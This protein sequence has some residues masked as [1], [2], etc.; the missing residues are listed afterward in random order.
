MSVSS[1]LSASLR[2]VKIDGAI[3]AELLESVKDQIVA[4]R[5]ASDEPLTLLID[6]PGG[7]PALARDLVTFLG[8]DGTRPQGGV[9]RTLATGTTGGSAAELLLSGDLVASMTP[10]VI[11]LGEG[12]HAPDVL[13]LA[14]RMFPR[15]L[16]T[17][18]RAS[19]YPS[20]Y[21]PAAEMF[22][23]EF[24]AGLDRVLHSLA[25]LAGAM[26]TEL[27]AGLDELVQD[28]AADLLRFGD[29]REECEKP[30]YAPP[31]ALTQLFSDLDPAVQAEAEH[32]LRAMNFILA[33]MIE[34]ED[35]PVLNAERLS[36][37]A[38]CLEHYAHWSPVHFGRDLMSAALLHD[39]L[40]FSKDELEETR[41]LASVREGLDES[42]SDR[43]YRR[44]EPFW[45][46]TLSIARFVRERNQPLDP[47]SA[48]WLGLLD[49]VVGTDLD[50]RE[51][52]GA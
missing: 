44:A 2:S 14:R 7:D 12:A 29:M 13:W 37:T 19:R 41:R 47:A 1:E 40:F 18:A 50:R 22:T 10:V 31:Q 38:G 35:E 5:S 15:M 23:D 45:A 36:A 30:S 26:W 11:R 32:R 9:V 34:A 42:L 16:D 8:L 27:P 33:R 6:S 28:A 17:F 24:D 52:P 49:I 21:G 46:F 3:D 43:V 39:D 4:L 48:W 20:R 51:R 25:F